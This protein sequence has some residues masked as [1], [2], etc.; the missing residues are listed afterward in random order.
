MLQETQPDREIDMQVLEMAAS[1]L[2]V[3]AHP[4]R[5]KMVELLLSGRLS[6]GE[7]AERMELAPNAVSQH[8]N[9]MK[10]HGIL[11][12]VR[13]GRTAYYHVTNINAQNVIKCIRDHG[14][15]KQ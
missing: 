3:L 13:V 4:H 11:G 14:C 6:V 1:V 5:L 2:K 12:V 9:Q 7:L 15:G 10:A 8:L